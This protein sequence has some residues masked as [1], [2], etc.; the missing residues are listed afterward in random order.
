M[1]ANAKRL[2][3]QKGQVS[4]VQNQNRGQTVSFSGIKYLKFNV[5]YFSYY[6]HYMYPVSYKSKVQEYRTICNGKGPFPFKVY[7]Q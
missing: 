7:A 4:S 3:E 6:H 5:P 1:Y 2:T